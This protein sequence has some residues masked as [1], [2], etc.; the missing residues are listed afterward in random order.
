MPAESD[1]ADVREDVVGDNQ[2][3][4]KEKPDH[5]FEDVIDNKMRLDHDEIKSHMRPC[6]LLELELVMALLQRHDEKYE[7]CVHL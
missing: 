1:T 3:G 5:A 6:K 4:G 7:T 2:C